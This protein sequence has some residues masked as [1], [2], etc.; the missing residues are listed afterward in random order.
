MILHQHSASS[1]VSRA[2][3]NLLSTQSIDLMDHPAYRPDLAF[4]DFFLFPHVKNKLR[5][6]RWSCW[7]VHKASFGNISVTN[8]CFLSSQNKNSDPHA[9]CQCS[10]VSG[11]DLI[12][13]IKS[14]WPLQT[15]NGFSICHCQHV[16]KIVCSQP[17][18]CWSYPD[19]MRKRRLQL[20]GMTERETTRKLNS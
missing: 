9:M 3:I 14:F 4:N 2:S 12:T 1:H 13:L 6:Q 15:L 16:T 5:G 18:G 10:D 7:S 19:K 17:S 20:T 11:I 8:H